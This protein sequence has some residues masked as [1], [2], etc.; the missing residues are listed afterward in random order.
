MLSLFKRK[1]KPAVEDEAIP[2]PVAEVQDIVEEIAEPADSPNLVRRAKQ[3][4]IKASEDCCALFDALARAQGMTRADLFQDMV[5]ERYE[6]LQ[7]Q[8]VELKV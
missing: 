3:Q 2:E 4:N 8:G 1:P 5:V 7:R 6:T